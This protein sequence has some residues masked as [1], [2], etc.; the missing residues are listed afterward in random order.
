MTQTLLSFVLTSNFSHLAAL[1][2]VDQELKRLVSKLDKNERETFIIFHSDN[3]GALDSSCNYPYKGGKSDLDEGGTL[4]PA[5]I[6]S[7]RKTRNLS[8]KTNNM[9]FFLI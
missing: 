1:H 5:F 9:V 8:K 4:S 6:Y 7:T 3:G 2:V